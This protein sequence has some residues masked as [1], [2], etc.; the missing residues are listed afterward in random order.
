MAKI[1][2]LV[3]FEGTEEDLAKQLAQ[4]LSEGIH[5]M[6]NINITIINLSTNNIPLNAFI[7]K[8]KERLCNPELFT[9][10]ALKRYLSLISDEEEIFYEDP[11]FGEQY[12]M[13][14]PTIKDFKITKKGLLISFPFEDPVE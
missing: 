2:R 4:S 10:G 5:N 6:S 11:N 9:V 1:A 7:N 12:E 13:I 8:E 3:I 14:K